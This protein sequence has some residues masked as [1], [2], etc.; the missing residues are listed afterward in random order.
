MV[1]A[2]FIFNLSEQFHN[3]VIPEKYKINISNMN[4]FSKPHM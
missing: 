1:E 4:Q 3:V 2:I